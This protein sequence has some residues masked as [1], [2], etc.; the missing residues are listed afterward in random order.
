MSTEQ[1]K[2]TSSKLDLME[3]FDNTPSE[4]AMIMARLRDREYARL[5]AL[6]RTN[7]IGDLLTP[8]SPVKTDEFVDAKKYTRDTARVIRIQPLGDIVHAIDSLRRA[9]SNDVRTRRQLDTADNR[10]NFDV[11]IF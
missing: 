6:I 9:E 8:F 10:T 2:R 5:Q 7:S 3:T 11:L 4:H 1:A